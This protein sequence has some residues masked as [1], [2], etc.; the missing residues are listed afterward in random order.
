MA[1]GGAVVVQISEIKFQPLSSIVVF[2]VKIADSLGCWIDQIYRTQTH[3]TSPSGHD[4][5]RCLAV[6]LA[7]V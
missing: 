6:N 3:R 5:Q 4:A 1:S 7:S 2:C